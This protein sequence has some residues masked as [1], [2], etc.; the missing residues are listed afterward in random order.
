[1]SLVFS[2]IVIVLLYGFIQKFSAMGLGSKFM[3]NLQRRITVLVVITLS[4]YLLL[5]RQF[6]PLEIP[7]PIS[8][9]PLSYST[10]AAHGG[11]S[12]SE[13]LTRLHQEAPPTLRRPAQCVEQ[14][15][16]LQEVTDDSERRD[17]TPVS[18]AEILIA[19]EAHHRA[20]KMIKTSPDLVPYKPRTRGIVTVGG[21]RYTG[22]VLVSLRMLRRTNSTLPVE[23]FMPTPEDY[24]EHTCKVVLPSLN[25]KCVALPQYEGIHI[26]TYQY[27]IFAVLLSSFEDVLFLDADNFPI[28]DPTEFIDSQPYRK[29]GYVLVSAPFLFPRH[30]SLTPR[31]GLISGGRPAPPTTSALSTDQHPKLRNTAL[32]S[33]VR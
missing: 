2:Y 29:T 16:N 31:S 18:D 8:E 10:P 1:L 27:K 24:D 6:W 32:P 9:V 19:R 26:E 12:I 7:I 21:G 23:V 15:V 13:F 25:A 20:V 22:T 17:V 11:E 4:L 5:R 33:L 14:H 28:V 30:A 3:F